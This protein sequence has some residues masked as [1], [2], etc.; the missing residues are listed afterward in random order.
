MACGQGRTSSGNRGEVLG[1][2]EVQE[3]ARML[4]QI[5]VQSCW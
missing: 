2:A 1:R 5:P 4:L 3:K